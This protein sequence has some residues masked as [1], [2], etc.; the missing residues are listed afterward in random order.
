MRLY[1]KKSKNKKGIKESL[2]I[3][4]T[5]QG[6]RYRKP[7]K[8]S[9][10]PKNRKI[11]EK[12]IIPVIQYQILNGEF[13]KNEM[14]TINQYMKKSFELQ[15]SNRKP[16]TS[17]DYRSKFDKHL[18]PTFGS[19]KLDEIK[20]TDIT[21][22]QN[23]ML[24]KGYAIRTI[25]SVR[26]MLNTLYE[27]ATKDEIIE[28]NPVRFASQLSKRNENKKKMDIEPFS[29]NEIQSIILNAHNKQM[30]NFYMLLFSTGMRGGEAIG[31]KWNQIN[32]ITKEISIIVQCT[33]G[34]LTS[35]K[36]D[37]YRTIPIIDSLMPFLNSQF[38]STGKYN[39][40][41]FLNQENKNFWD[42]SKITQHY[43]KKDL[44]K[45]NVLYRKLH[46]TRH[47][48]CSTMISTGEDINYVSKI[49]GHSS[50]KMTL[51]KY[52][53]YI[54]NDKKGFGKAFNAIIVRQ[55]EK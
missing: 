37:S 24:E 28:K 13:F 23:D 12:Q 53:K 3:D 50:T 49:A 11:A 1:V 19:K 35:P 41:V 10:T 18:K 42:I 38:E 36:W 43:W 9:N 46:A 55:F 47:T 40:F 31:L 2:W 4:F 54:P 39:S 29:I 27:D 33:K 32:F 14:P 34:E 30:K 45:A 20:G 7:L 17:K 52:S 6:N 44:Q 48:F 26:G 21:L 8:L 5:Y 25:K 22:W 15:K 51:E 16:R